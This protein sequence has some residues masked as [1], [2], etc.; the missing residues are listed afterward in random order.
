M[1]ES[2]RGPRKTLGCRRQSG[3]GVDLP[4]ARRECRTSTLMVSQS[5]AFG[6]CRIGRTRRSFSLAL[7]ISGLLTPKTCFARPFP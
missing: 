5:G 1:G 3:D 7:T 4:D 2:D 6:D